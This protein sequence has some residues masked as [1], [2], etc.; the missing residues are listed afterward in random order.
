MDGWW[1]RTLT[2]ESLDGGDVSALV[3]YLVLEKEDAVLQLKAY[4]GPHGTLATE[5]GESLYIYIYG[6]AG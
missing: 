1:D 2:F 3:G 5:C 6:L 4:V